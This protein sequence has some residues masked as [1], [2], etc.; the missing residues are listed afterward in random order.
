MVRV[1]VGPDE[2]LCRILN[3]STVDI[4]EIAGTIQSLSHQE[5]ALHDTAK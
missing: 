3:T 5:D 4:P 2:T 1:T